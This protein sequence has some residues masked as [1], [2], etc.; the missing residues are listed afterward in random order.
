MGRLIVNPLLVVVFLLRVE[1][2][3]QTVAPIAVIP[4]ELAANHLYVQA[5]LNNSPPLLVLIDSGAPESIV[6]HTSTIQ[7]GLPISGDI[8]VPGFGSEKPTAGQ[9]TVINQVTLNG[10]TLSRVPALSVSTDF[11]SRLVGHAT[12]AIIGSDLFKRY[13]VEI[14]YSDRNLKLYDPET[15]VTPKDGCQLALS[16]GLYPKI[17]AQVINNDGNSIDAAFVVDTGSNILFVT[18]SFGDTH[19]DL[20]IDRKTVEAPGRKMLSGVTTGRVGRIRAI[21]L[22]D[23]IVADPIAWF[24]QDATGAGAGDQTV[25]GYL[26]MSILEQFTTIVDYRHQVVTFK[27]NRT[28]HNA[29]QYDMT[30]LHIFAAGPTYHDFTVDYIRSD[31]PAAR[32]D[33]EVGDKIDSANHK[34]AS[35]LSLDDLNQLFQRRGTLRLS[36]S[37]NGTRLTKKLKLKPVI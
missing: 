8:Q 32:S 3:A 31:S 9:Q 18:R 11:V 16:V 13:V 33:I 15:Y 12:D 5:K 20:A 34:P 30:G 29:S 24:S 14:D 37:R 17:N 2:L 23:C 21:R 22:A 27:R 19:P 25:S 26:G 35:N 10:A 4:F 36:I 6:D 7:L 1:A 28:R